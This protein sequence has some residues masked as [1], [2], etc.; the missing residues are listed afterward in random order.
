MKKVVFDTN[1]CIAAFFWNGNPRKIYEL[2]KN[3][4]LKLFYSEAILEELIRVLAYKK[5]RLSNQEM[6][7]IINDFIKTA[8]L[9][10]VKSEINVITK[11]PTD[12]MFLECAINSK[13]GFIISGDNHL[14]DIK[15]YRR[16]NIVSPKDFVAGELYH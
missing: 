1:V 9:V 11:D 4:K 8:N 5:F 16:I 14:L 13:S 6:L 10:V 2:A 7:P 12:N 15:H 3:N